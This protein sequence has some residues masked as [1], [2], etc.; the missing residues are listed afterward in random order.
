LAKHFLVQIIRPLWE[1]FAKMPYDAPGLHHKHYYPNG[2]PTIDQRHDWCFL[3]T[4]FSYLKGTAI[5]SCPEPVI[6][7]TAV[8]FYTFGAAGW[9]AAHGKYDIDIPESIAAAHSTLGTFL[10][11]L[12]RHISI[13][14]NFS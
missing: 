5:V 1:N 7:F 2:K 13:F 3:I 4:P 12:V 11:L 14:R 9:N 10:A 6:F 8:A